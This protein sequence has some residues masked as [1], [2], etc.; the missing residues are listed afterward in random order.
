[1]NGSQNIT[2]ITPKFTGSC[3]TLRGVPDT[4]RL[5][6][7]GDK[8]RD[9]VLVQEA[10]ANDQF[11]D[12]PPWASQINGVAKQHQKQSTWEAID[13][14]ISLLYVVLIVQTICIPTYKK[15]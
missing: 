12:D 14:T 4:L 8:F 7:G 5:R 13:T 2:G 11:G 3:L 1:M 6:T 15:L 9:D 10:T